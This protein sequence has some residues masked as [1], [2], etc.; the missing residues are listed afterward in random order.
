MFGMSPLFHVLGFSLTVDAI[1][2]DHQLIHYSS[3]PDVH[4]VL[5][6]LS[7]L[8]PQAALI[9]PSILQDMSTTARALKTLEK[10]QYVLFG[11][12]PLSTEAGEIISKYCQLIPTIGSTELGH[13][14]PTIS[15]TSPPDWKY[16]Q[17]PYYPDI[18]MEAHDAGLFEMVIRR[19][20]NGRLLHGVFHVFPKLQEWRTKDLFSKHPMKDGLWRFEGRTDDIII[21]S[22]GEK[23]NPLEMEGVIECHNLVRKAMIAGQGM[24]ECV[25]LVEP[26]W[27]KMDGPEEDGNFIEM[28]WDSVE[29]ANK[30]G[31][32]YAYIEKDRV[33]IASREKPFQVNA[34]G[35]LRRALVCRDYAA[36]ISTLGSDDNVGPGG[37]SSEVFQG[38]DMETFI[39][40][41]VSSVSPHV[42]LAEETDFFAAGLDSLQMIRMARSITREISMGSKNS[43]GIHID[44]QI[45]YK[46]CTIKR[47]SSY[48]SDIVQG[49]VRGGESEEKLEDVQAALNHLINKYTT[50]LPMVERKNTQVTPRSNIILTGSTGSLGSYFLDVLLSETSIKTVYC[51][52][53]SPD[54]FERQ[55]S[56]FHDRQLN[57]KALLTPKA[58]FLTAD[59]G[60]KSLG[61]SQNKYNELLNTADTIV[62]NAWKVDFNL[63]VDS[64]EK[65]HIR[66][67][68][69]LLDL[70]ICS[71]KR[72][73]MYFVS[74]I[75]T[76]SGWETSKGKIPEDILPDKV[77]PPMQGYGQSKYVGENICLAAS[78]RSGIPVTILRVGQVA[79]P[80]TKSGGCWNPDEWFPSLIFT[81]KSMGIVPESLGM[82]VEWIPVVGYPYLWTSFA[83]HCRTHSPR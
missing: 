24:T 72:A 7:T 28:I 14:P 56:S 27:D 40:H 53:R 13:V 31:P 43:N 68:R 5:D 55:R 48:I 66:G 35:T 77:E 17:W 3:K 83:N 82:A 44:P 4:S 32:S 38:Y 62:H 30:Q 79:G 64:F 6:A 33:G 74:S 67:T 21:L 59:L 8:C 76:T 25:L 57:V 15:K 29:Y 16:Y 61:L 37:S 71:R 75:A 50:S 47:L 60:D 23:V 20:E 69:N 12:G 42:E 9:P 10:I 52:N 65:D 63:S 41:V 19:S 18:H 49:N 81:S 58:E 2:H 34:K 46:Y 80:T 36:E 22:N 1:F 70:S 78:T 45:I 26:D 11:G 54:A 39:R 73:H 51:L